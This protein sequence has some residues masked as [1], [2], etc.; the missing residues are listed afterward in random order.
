MECAIGKFGVDGFIE[1][2]NELISQ[3]GHSVIG[4]AENPTFSYTVGRWQRGLPEV[5]VFGVNPQIATPFSRGTNYRPSTLAFPISCK[6]WTQSFGRLLPIMRIDTSAPRASLVIPT[7]GKFCSL[8]SPIPRMYSLTKMGL[9]SGSSPRCRC[10]IGHKI[11][12]LMA[13][14]DR[15]AK[16]KISYPGGVWVRVPL[17]APLN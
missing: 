16:F 2:T 4:V 15:R 5:I 13:K 11:K 9:K 3:Y 10:W 1:K 17:G 12:A 7:I 6:G 14:L 8:S